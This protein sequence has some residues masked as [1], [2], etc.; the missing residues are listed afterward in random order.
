MYPLNHHIG[1]K[2]VVSFFM[3]AEYQSR[4]AYRRAKINLLKTQQKI[5]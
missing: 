2:I 4:N 3:F 5:N 1:F